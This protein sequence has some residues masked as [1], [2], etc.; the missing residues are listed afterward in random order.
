MLAYTNNPSFWDVVWW[1]FIAF[2]WIMWIF[3]V[4]R[5]FI[6]NFRRTDHGGF[7]KAMWTIAIVF[8]PVLGVVFYLIAR[9]NEVAVTTL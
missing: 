8:L 4:I 2:V 9:P 5:V 7:A 1:M 6:D 3:V